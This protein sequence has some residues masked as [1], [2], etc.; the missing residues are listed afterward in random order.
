MLFK[1]L[2][3]TQ[4]IYPSYETIYTTNLK[5][6]FSKQRY[7]YTCIREQAILTYI[8]VTVALL[9]FLLS[10]S[11]AP[12]DISSSFIFSL[13]AS[14]KAVFCFWFFWFGFAP[15]GSRISAAYKVFF[16]SYPYRHLRS[17]ISAFIIIHHY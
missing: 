6:Y 13:S 15:C 11:I 17:I 9:S 12:K 2:V 14:S 10:V 5:I 8:P 7:V 4:N 3:S 1:S 16:Q